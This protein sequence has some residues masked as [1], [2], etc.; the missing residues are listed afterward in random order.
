MLAISINTHLSFFKFTKMSV[1]FLEI[2][3]LLGSNFIGIILRPQQMTKAALLPINQEI[4]RY[5]QEKI[6]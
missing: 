2:A 4:L 5:Q 6:P 3:G 1:E